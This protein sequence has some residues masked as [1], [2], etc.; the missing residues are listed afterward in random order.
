M[1]RGAQ[2]Y[3]RYLTGEDEALVEL[4]RDHKDGLILFLNRYVENL[5]I[6]EE[7]A[8]ETFFRLVTRRPWFTPKYSFKTW[9]YTIGRNL[10]MDHLKKAAHCTDI[11]PEELDRMHNETDDLERG[12]LR[13]AQKI[14]LHRAM[15]ALRAEYGGALY[16]KFFEELN[17]EEIA[18][19]M[20]KSK[21]QVENL[22]YQAKRALKSQ[23]E[24]EGFVYEEL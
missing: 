12:Y 2:Q 8:E 18:K 7:L 11:A 22:L 10:A 6:A 21:R 20:K 9:L 19:I 1:D 13:Q 14:A 15:S 3:Q 24:Q 17:N 4:I 16:L 23:L 5:Y